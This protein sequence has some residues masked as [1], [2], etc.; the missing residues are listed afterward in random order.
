MLEKGDGFYAFLVQNALDVIGVLDADGTLRYVSPAVE[1][2]LGYAPEEVV[3]TEVFDYV[4]P[5]DLVRAFLALTETIETPGALPPMGF[6]ARCADGTWRHVEVVRNN[7]LDDLDVG[8][9]VINV[10]DVTERKAAEAKLREAEGRYRALVE[11]IP[12]V[13]YID[14]VDEV[15]S[16]IYMSPQ[17]EKML[18]YA[19]EEWLKDPEFWTKILHPDDRERMLAESRRNNETGDP[20]GAEYRMISRN[21]RVVWVRDEAVLVRNEAG[22]PLYWQGVF[23]D[24]TERKEVE[25][26]LRKSERSLAAAQ[27]IA[28]I[29][30]FDYSVVKDEARWSD[31]LYRIFGFAP[32]RFVPTYK[33]FL[34]SVHPDDRDLIRRSIRVALHGKRQPTVDYRIVRSDGKVRVV[35]SHYE[36]V[37]NGSGRVV[38]LVGTVHDITER[39]ALEERL[40]RQA[41]HDPLTG[42]PNRRLFVD[43]LGH[44]L[45]RT[46]RTRRRAGCPVAV[47]FMDLDDFKGVNDSMGHEA[48]DLLLLRVAERLKGCLRPQDTLARFGGDEFIVL[49]EDVRSPGDAVRVAGRIMRVFKDPFVVEGRELYARTS[50]GIALGEGSAERPEDLLRNADTAMY[51]AKDEG[52]SGYRLFDPAMHEGVLRRLATEND[53]R[54][55]VQR[56]EFV[57]H[58]QPIVC[59]RTG[60]VKAV[61]ALVRWDHPQRGLLSPDEFVPIA[62][63]SGLVVPMGEW[64]L[65]EACLRAKE[66]QDDHLRTPPLAISVN[67]SAKQLSRPDLA[68]TVEGILDETGLEGNRLTLDVTETVYVRALEANTRALGRLE[69]LGV[70]CSID[71]FGTGYSSLSYLKR[72]PADAI[73][74]DKS[75]VKGLGEDAGDTA[76]VRMTIELAHTFGME[77]VAEGV[78][79]GEQARM[80]SEMGC[81]MAQG[82]FFA[83]PLPPE[84]VPGFLDAAYQRR[85][86]HRDHDNADGLCGGR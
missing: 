28:H 23:Y 64:V 65:R 43:R 75:F 54:R 80:L 77:V 62:E 7:R 45:R 86:A 44:A 85:P 34:R 25:E 59:P 67:L 52:A 72:L 19:P 61:E 57:V 9:V 47:L 50:I 26:A 6:R 15:S 42:L 56:K 66:W 11:Q 1:A 55:A 58:Y 39:K 13:V 53:L 76:I 83:K 78:E 37:R 18:G 33:T 3:G 5:D 69:G 70:R 31:E 79:T 4:H 71:D 48:G 73:K 84:A 38:N 22:E 74:I 49:I 8:G 36:V 29:G 14:H 68:Q 12:A 63:E 16:A 81:D 27:R 2:M 60:G 10:R 24:L 46:R 20:F 32:R 82:F 21:G 30:N 17:V 41:L 51:R 35:R 40:E